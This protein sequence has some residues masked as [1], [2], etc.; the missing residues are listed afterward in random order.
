M[1]NTAMLE[2]MLQTVK[3]KLPQYEEERD[4]LNDTISDSSPESDWD[5]LHELNVDIIPALKESKE[6][7]ERLIDNISYLE[8]RENLF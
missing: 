5:R 4:N 6:G 1:K 7:L 2:D 8:E 3:V